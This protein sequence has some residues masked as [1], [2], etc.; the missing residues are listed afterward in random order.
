MIWEIIAVLFI[1]G[2]IFC[3]HY[4]SLLFKQEYVTNLERDLAP[5]SSFHMPSRAEYDAHCPPGEITEPYP[6]YDNYALIFAEVCLAA[7]EI[8]G[9]LSGL[10]AIPYAAAPFLL[11]SGVALWVVRGV[12]AGPASHPVL[13]AVL[14][15]LAYAALVAVYVFLL[16][17]R[18]RLEPDYSG[19][20]WAALSEQ[21]PRPEAEIRYIRSIVSGVSGRPGDTGLP[22]RVRRYKRFTVFMGL[23][24]FAVFVFLV[25]YISGRILVV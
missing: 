8:H 16:V 18:A 6:S 20:H 14:C 22:P 3:V 21:C 25:L 15:C 10:L 4:F 7:D 1:C 23:V 9:S 11:S 19:Y 2:M 24:C 5:V 17:R 13:A 12:F